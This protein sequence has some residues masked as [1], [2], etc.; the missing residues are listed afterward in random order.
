LVTDKKRHVV[1]VYRVPG[2]DKDEVTGMLTFSVVGIDGSPKVVGTVGIVFHRSQDGNTWTGQWNTGAAH[3][4]GNVTRLDGYI[5]GKMCVVGL[6]LP[7]GGGGEES[8]VDHTC[9]M[10][11]NQGVHRQASDH[12]HL[13]SGK[14]VT[15][16]QHPS[17]KDTRG[18]PRSHHRAFKSVR[19]QKSQ[20]LRR[21]V[22][23]SVVVAPQQPHPQPQSQ[24]PRETREQEFVQLGN[25]LWEGLIRILLAVGSGSLTSDY[26]VFAKLISRV[27]ECHSKMLS[28]C[29]GD[30]QVWPHGVA[31]HRNGHP[32]ESRGTQLCVVPGQFMVPLISERVRDLLDSGENITLSLVRPGCP[33]IKC[34]WPVV[35]EVFR[36]P[37][38]C[39]DGVYEVHVWVRGSLRSLNTVRV[40]APA[41]KPAPEP[42]SPLSMLAAT[43]SATTTAAAAV[44]ATPPVFAPMATSTQLGRAIDY[45][46]RVNAATSPYIEVAFEGGAVGGRLATSVCATTPPMWLRGTHDQ[47][48]EACFMCKKESSPKSICRHYTP[49]V[50]CTR[51]GSEGGDD[52]VEDH[53]ARKVLHMYSTSVQEALLRVSGLTV[54]QLH[55]AMAS[56]GL[57]TKHTRIGGGSTVIEVVFLNACGSSTPWDKSG[58]GV[59]RHVAAFVCDGVRCGGNGVAHLSNYHNICR[60]WATTAGS[61]THK[62]TLSTPSDTDDGSD[63]GASKRQ[64]VRHE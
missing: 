58:C 24:S 13:C 33:D 40:T 48:R 55:D 39:P 6:R 62:H 20:R 54:E 60:H 59:D 1:T 14:N 5:A 53:E 19:A 31:A 44:P 3:G 7:G 29:G 43:A 21:C 57:V 26:A 36:I 15:C 8:W 17:V 41:P 9:D 61:P 4:E 47:V 51:I 22:G 2:V 10:T 46:Q 32:I 30:V 45:P 28:W 27:A 12:V 50:R 64:C 37:E 63:E 23:A 11:Y 52:T 16:T 18:L 38:T 42:Q 35:D 34:A 25:M 49:C 56:L